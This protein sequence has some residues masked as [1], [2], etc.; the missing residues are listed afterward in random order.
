MGIF[1]IFYN[2]LWVNM[3]ADLSEEFLSKPFF[4][5]FQLKLSLGLLE[6]FL[7]LIMV[8]IQIA[9]EDQV[10]EGQIQVKVDLGEKQIK[11][12]QDLQNQVQESEGLLH[13]HVQAGLEET[14]RD[15]QATLVRRGVPEVD[16]GTRNLQKT[17]L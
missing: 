5:Y 12:L 17:M 11:E 15:T 9:A 7:Q 6:G 13:K 1:Q 3:M 2:I 16:T 10:Q 4:I 14:D 8:T